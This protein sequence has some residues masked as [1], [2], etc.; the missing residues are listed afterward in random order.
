[1]SL[2]QEV[3]NEDDLKAKDIMDRIRGF[4]KRKTANENASEFFPEDFLNF[5]YRYPESLCERTIS[6]KLKLI[7]ALYYQEALDSIADVNDGWKGYSYEDLAIL[8]DRSK[9]SIFQAIHE[10]GD[11]AKQILTDKKLKTK[12]HDLALAELVEQEKTRILAEKSKDSLEQTN[13]RL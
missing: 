3:E 11:Q 4:Y 9:A 2:E 10:K 1:M 12:V 7:I 6:E 8:F 5:L 13:E